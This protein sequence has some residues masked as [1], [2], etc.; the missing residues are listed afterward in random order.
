MNSLEIK[1]LFEPRGIAVVGAS[2]KPGKIG[3]MILYNILHSGYRGRIYP[4][5]PAGGE[6][7]GLPVHRNLA[8]I[9]GV[10]DVA[11]IAIPAK[12]V[13]P[14]VRQCADKGVKFLSVISS[15]FSEVG[16]LAEEQELTR[17]AKKHGMRVLGP[18]IFGHYSSSASLNATFGPRDIKPG[19]V[20]IITQSGALGVA[21]IGKT[22]IQNI[23]LSAIISVGNKADVDEADLLEYLIEH[24]ETRSILMYIEGVQHGER[25]VEVLKRATRVKPVVV[26]KSGRSKRGAIAAASHTGSLAGSDEIFDAIMQQCGVL[27]SESIQEALDWCK[28]L[29]TTPLPTGRNTVIITNGGGVGVLA[30]DA[31]EKYQ[32]KLYED[33]AHLKS[34]FEDVTHGFGSTKNPIDLTG[35]ATTQEYITALTSALEDEQIHAVISLYCELRNCP[36]DL[37]RTDRYDPTGLFGLSTGGQTDYFFTVRR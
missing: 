15:G 13:F 9:D 33:K 1:Y 36:H 11:I 21:M 23:G 12:F 4:V 8:D 3:G 20:A 32:V 18:N 22:A 14:V 10:I 29:S 25:L 19:N 6:I 37:R 16:N 17:Y 30:T 34:V 28:F 7:G 26:I 27:R 24:D 2:D 5:N 35:E 31:C